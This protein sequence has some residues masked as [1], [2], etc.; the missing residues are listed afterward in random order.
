MP[1][2][3]SNFPEVKKVILGRRVGLVF[4]PSNP[5]EIAEAVNKILEDKKTYQ[6]MSK[7]AIE[8]IKRDYNWEAEGKKLLGIYNRLFMERQNL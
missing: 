1:V 6:E 5:K 7:N 4:N 8:A 2:V 3:A